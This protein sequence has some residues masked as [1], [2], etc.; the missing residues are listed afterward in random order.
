MMANERRQRAARRQET[1]RY[2]AKLTQ[3]INDIKWS[4]QGVQSTYRDNATALL[5]TFYLI[6]EDINLTQ[7][8]AVTKAGLYC[9]SVVIYIKYIN[10]K[11]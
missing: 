6:L 4:H 1:S 3:W 9:K 7:I 10:L 5:V 11:I 8:E 2:R